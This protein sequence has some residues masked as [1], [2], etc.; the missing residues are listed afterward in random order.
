MSA[1]ACR[2]CGSRVRSFLLLSSALCLLGTQRTLA[3][4]PLSA[5]AEDLSEFGVMRCDVYQVR[6]PNGRLLVVRG[7]LRNPYDATVTGVRLVIRLLSPGAQR[8]QL[9][10]MERDLN[11]TIEPGREIMF[12]REVDTS[13]AY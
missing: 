6:A 2:R 5:G 11:V 8:R 7:R 10:R 12:S 4:T 9:D 3:Q 1:A 13:Y